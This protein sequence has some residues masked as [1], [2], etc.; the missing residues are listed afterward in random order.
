MPLNV[1]LNYKEQ[2]PPWTSHPTYLGEGVVLDLEAGDVLVLVGGDGDELRGREGAREDL[3]DVLDVAA[4]QLRLLLAAHP[5]HVHARLVLVQRVEHDLPVAR[6]LIGQLHLGEADGLLRPVA[7]VIG[8]VGVAV[9]R[10]RWVGLRL[11]TCNL[12]LKS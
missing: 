5:H 7:A 4:G 2:S 3:L 1:P 6:R 11:S 8:R 9:H 12:K 10:V